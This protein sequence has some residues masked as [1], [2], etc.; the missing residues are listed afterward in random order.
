M[1]SDKLSS[2]D[3]VP[4][5]ILIGLIGRIWKCSFSPILASILFYDFC[6]RTQ[7]KILLPYLWLNMIFHLSMPNCNLF[8]CQFVD[9]APISLVTLTSCVCLHI[10]EILYSK[11]TNPWLSQTVTILPSPSLFVFYFLYGVLAHQS[12]YL[13]FFLFFFYLFVVFLMFFFFFLLT[14]FFFKKDFYF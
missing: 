2:A 4:M 1:S 11:D 3:I 5:Y 12:S 14:I 8:L 6:P 7:W 10:S 13:W 9:F